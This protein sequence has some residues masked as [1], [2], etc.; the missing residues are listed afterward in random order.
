MAD[1]SDSTQTLRPLAETM[2]LLS[3]LEGNLN[4]TKHERVNQYL[5]SLKLHL[6]ITGGSDG[7]CSFSPAGGV[8]VVGEGEGE[9]VHGR[10]NIFFYPSLNS[11]LE[12][13]NEFL[14]AHKIHQNITGDSDGE[15]PFPLQER[16]CVGAGGG[17]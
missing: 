11:K 9:G 5:E 12:R 1:S 7:E 2:A 15:C 10:R 14:E 3:G 4:L 8:V 16:S 13:V 17:E 6:N